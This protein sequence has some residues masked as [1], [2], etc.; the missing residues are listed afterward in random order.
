MGINI[1][2]HPIPPCA[3]TRF[4]TQ[5]DLRSKKIYITEKPHSHTNRTEEKT[6][7]PRPNSTRAWGSITGHATAN[8]S[9][10]KSV[11]ATSPGASGYKTAASSLLRSCCSLDRRGAKRPGTATSPFAAQSNADLDYG[12]IVRMLRYWRI[13]TYSVFYSSMAYS[14]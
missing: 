5:S 9:S 3:I 8:P 4:Q 10:V 13:H 7:I 12:I 6:K 2:C 1:K 14:G 11:G